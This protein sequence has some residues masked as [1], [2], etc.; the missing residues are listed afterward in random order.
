[1]DV[2]EDFSILA[3]KQRLK[4]RN[5]NSLMNFASVDAQLDPQVARLVEWNESGVKKPSV[6]AQCTLM[7]GL[8]YMKNK[9]I[10]SKEWM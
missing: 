10:F 3:E 9:I 7:K 2:F 5:S 8:H 1:M 6:F 4:L